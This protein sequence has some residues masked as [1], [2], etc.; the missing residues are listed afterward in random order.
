[1]KV[2][3]FGRTSNGKSTCINA[4]LGKWQQGYFQAFISLHGA[5]DIPKN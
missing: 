5:V 2:V 1:M 3:F 4:L